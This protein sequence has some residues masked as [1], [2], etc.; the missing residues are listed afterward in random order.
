MNHACDAYVWNYGRALGHP[1][2]S[3]LPGSKWEDVSV[4]ILRPLYSLR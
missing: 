3:L 2:G 1:V 4:E